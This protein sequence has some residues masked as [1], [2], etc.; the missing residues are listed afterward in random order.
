[1]ETVQQKGFSAGILT[2]RPMNPWSSM[3]TQPRETVRQLVLAGHDGR[4]LLLASLAGIAEVLARAS[5]RNMGDSFAFSNILVLAVLLGPVAGLGALYFWSWLTARTGRWLGGVA[6]AD[7]LRVPIAWG[8]LPAA[9]SLALWAVAIVLLGPDLF[10]AQ[11]PRVD[12]NPALGLFLMLVAVG[13]IVLGI[14]SVVLL[15]KGV[16]EVQGFASAWRGF[17]NLVLGGLVLIAA[18]VV[19]LIVIFGLAVVGH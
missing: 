8:G 13:W 15:A 19:L 2:A 12:A 4:V 1:M 5:S 7:A 18:V 9:A 16:A 14:W 11:T 17:G 6:D 3:W 10:T